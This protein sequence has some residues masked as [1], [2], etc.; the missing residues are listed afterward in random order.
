MGSV[1][2]PAAQFLCDVDVQL[3]R[4]QENP[5]CSVF[6]RTVPSP[7][8]EVRSDTAVRQLA[9]RGV[10]PGMGLGSRLVA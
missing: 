5:V 6:N 1:V 4:L 3:S 2:D 8:K 9:S 10:A 7:D